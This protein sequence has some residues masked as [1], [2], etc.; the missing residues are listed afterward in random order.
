MTT[1]YVQFIKLMASG[2]PEQAHLNRQSH[3]ID[4]TVNNWSPCDHTSVGWAC[5]IVE[6]GG[7]QLRANKILSAS[8]GCEWEDWGHCMSFSLSGSVCS[9]VWEQ[10]GSS[11]SFSM[12]RTGG[13]MGNVVQVIKLQLSQLRQW[14][15][16]FM[17]L[18]GWIWIFVG[19]LPIEYWVA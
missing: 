19:P 4:Q 13:L 11:I 12:S 9:C 17:I 10:W 7:P 14:T 8:M 1:S 5:F 18:A 3:H 6:S 16:P 15:T 2:C